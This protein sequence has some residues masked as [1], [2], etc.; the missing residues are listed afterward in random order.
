MRR[1][2]LAIAAICAV[3]PT[4][5]QD[6]KYVEATGLTIV[7]KVFPDTPEPYKRIDT[8]K[9]KGWTKK[10][11]GL[12]DMSSGIICAFRT[13]AP[14]IN[15][16][17]TVVGGRGSNRG[18]RGFDLYIKKDGRWLWAGNASIPKG[19]DEEKEVKLVTDMAPGVKECIVYFPTFSV[20]GSVKVGVPEGCSLEAGEKPFKH[21]I[22]LYGS[23]FTHGASATR[24]GNT[25][26]AFL[27]RMTGLQFNSLGV[28]GDC[29]MQPQFL[30]ALKD[31]KAD[32]FFFDTFSNPNPKEIR[33]RTFG[34]IEGIQS[35]HPG[36]PLIFIRTIRRENRNFDTKKEAFEA[37]KMAVADS[38]MAIAV[39]RY[40]DVYYIKTS[41]ASTADQETTNDGIHPSDFGYYIWANNIKKPL[42]KILRKY[43]IR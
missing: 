2:I 17:A 18:D 37:E 7:G 3:V 39:K 10:D 40:K 22:V 27:S 36:V 41:D 4:L 34:F 24:S 13:D 5:A 26:P 38:V 1:L 6:F 33:E 8:G 19:N 12:I 11:L 14:A 43:S 31:A 35:T 30:N 29:K 25:L 32:A 28:S 16:R 21:D 9:Y 42:L 20:M 23:S 15:M